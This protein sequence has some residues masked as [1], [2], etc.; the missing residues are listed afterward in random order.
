MD[1]GLI[2]SGGMQSLV[3]TLPQ[4]NDLTFL[5]TLHTEKGAQNLTKWMIS[6]A[7]GHIVPV[8]G[9]SYASLV[10]K[11]CLQAMQWTSTL[12]EVGEQAL[13]YQ[14]SI[15]QETGWPEY[16]T[17]KYNTLEEMLM[18]EVGNATGRDAAKMNQISWMA[19]HLVPSFRAAG[20]DPA[21]LWEI[22]SNYTKAR[23]AVPFLRDIQRSYCDKI[24]NDVVYTKESD[25]TWKY[26]YKG[27]IVEGLGG[28]Q[29]AEK[30][31]RNFVYEYLDSEQLES[32]VGA[33]KAVIGRVID[34]DVSYRDLKEELYGSGPIQ[35][36][37]YQ[38]GEN[39]DVLV[40][41]LK[42]RD[43][44][45][46]SSKLEGMVNFDYAG[47]KLSL[48]TRIKELS[49]KLD[50][51]K[52][53]F[54]ESTWTIE[55][56]ESGIW[57][58]TVSQLLALARDKYTIFQKDWRWQMGD[59]DAWLDI[60]DVGQEF[61]LLKLDSEKGGVI[62]QALDRYYT[63]AKWFSNYKSNFFIRSVR[64]TVF[65]C[66]AVSTYVTVED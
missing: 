51:V 44:G 28:K 27:I 54:T 49:E 20:E 26:S 21:K 11:S 12:G 40:I 8:E 15:A 16:L 60:Y 50:L 53:S 58:P 32:L 41:P 35:G 3:A 23:T 14:A 63:D 19:E 52:L 47:G 13:L 29:E 6:A 48:L 33:Y 17:N 37:R 18:T 43:A 2:L 1:Q 46:I 55:E 31:F 24:E 10:A 56:S 7:L 45:R 25:G 57:F 5:T 38:L 4:A 42:T 9:D 65:L 34:P 64:E 59:E 66:V 62:S 22:T 61:Q 36:E 39:R 30:H